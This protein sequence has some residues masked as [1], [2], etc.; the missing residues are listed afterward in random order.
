MKTI[1]ALLIL[2]ATQAHSQSA[3]DGPDQV[4]DKAR[5]LAAGFQNP[6]NEARP[7]AYWNWLNGAVTH[8]ALTRDLEEA[9]AKGLG[10][11]EMWDTEAM[12]N[13]DGFVPAGPPFMGP[14]SVAAMH[15]AMKEAKRLGLDLGLIT[16]SGWNAG[17]P[18]VS[19][20]MASKNLF[21]ATEV[22]TGPAQIS[23]KLAFPEVPRDCPKGADGLPKWMLDVAVLAWPDSKDKVIPDLSQVLD[24]SDK[25]QGGE[26]HWT[27]PPGKWQVARF[28]CSNNGQQ[29]IAAS[30]NSKGPFIDFLDP[31]ATRFHFK[32]IIDKLGLKKGGDPAC[33]LKT[34]EVD[35]MELHPG[36]QWTPKFPEWFKQYHG[37]SPI[38]W[39]PV[40]VGWTVGDKEQSDCFQ[41][42]FNKTVS[43]LLIFSHYTTGSKVCAEYGL[44]LAG[45]AG[46]PGPPIWDTCPVDALKALGNV[47]IP[48]GEFWIRHRNM[49]LVKEIASASH[50]YGK[51]Y[52]DAESWTTWRRWMDSPF[53]RKQIVDR[54]FCEGLNRITYHGYSHSPVEAGFPGQTYHA[55][56]DMNP[57]VVW[58]SKARPFM[59]YLARCCHLLQQGLFV[60]DAAYFYGDQAPNFWP[61]FHSVPDK[62]LLPGLGAGYDYDVVN[63]DIILNRML[64][65]DGR[66]TLPDGMSYRVL[67]LPEQVH[68]P[69]AV[70]IK[71]E[72]LV[73]EGA[74]II[75]PQP[76]AVPGMR[77]HADQTAQLRALADKM[78]GPCDG[79]KVTEHHHGKGNVV[80]GLSAR[81]YLARQSIE[82]DFACLDATQAANLDYIHRQTPEVD[83]YFVRNTTLSPVHANCRF[84]VEHRGAPQFWDPSDGSSVPLFVHE[85][86]DG[87]TRVLIDLPPGGSAFV[88]FEK[89]KGADGV[90]SLASSTADASLPA[91]QVVSLDGVKTV[92]QVWQNGQYTLT[93]CAGQEY[94]TA[95]SQLPTPLGISDNWTI[96]FDPKWGAP[97]KVAF[98]KLLSWA[99][100]ENEGIKYYSGLGVY[101]RTLEVP[102]DWLASG[103]GVHLDLGDVR[104]LAEVFVNGKSAGVLWKAPY[105][106]DITGLAKPGAND[107]KIEV[108]NLWINRLAGDMNLPAERRYTRTNMKPVRDMGGDETWKVQPAGLLGPVRLLPS[109]HV[110]IP[111]ATRPG[112]PAAIMNHETSDTKS[113]IGEK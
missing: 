6:G 112:P 4:S 29:L 15:H 106:S 1:I 38:A 35:S 18:W 93:D 51:P 65:R 105:R 91:P 110:K 87:G 59:D 10:G 14:E 50:I 13:Q 88:V 30:P 39:L 85:A 33:P 46:G 19:P 92:A 86:V 25:M 41:Y 17:G 58:W 55:G 37:Y 78:W 28:V 84:R 98:P 109:K 73:A 113:P 26:L 69:L 83:L 108:M 70:L 36:I 71:L 74:T 31:D 32:Y 8:S 24:L 90:R 43:D 66:I 9:K 7:R 77:N 20:E 99:D 42:D 96:A 40:L 72:Q 97:A 79:T 103:R 53:V 5:T 49:F 95:V 63:S 102:A 23:R 94:Q 34:L 80:W 22:V 68:M 16:S 67:V 3:P 52:V 104:E 44:Q 60:A 12:R 21:V 107:L 45:E 76:L 2:A 47:D 111:L 100:H 56:V 64:V 11:L 48:R 82:P 57:Q 89:R 61:L 75:G 81:D 54:A 62:L 101:T 27:V